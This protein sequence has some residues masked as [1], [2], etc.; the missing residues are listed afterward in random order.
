MIETDFL[1]VGGG[2]AGST[3]AKYLSISNI[4]NILIQKNLNFKKP[5]GGGVRQDAFDEFNLDTSI[6]LKRIHEIFL[7]FKTKRIKVDIKETPLAIV[8]RKQF[9]AYLRDE[10]KK[11]G[12]IVHEAK[13]LDFEI[14]EEYVISIVKF[15]E[16]IKQIKST[17]LIAADGVHSS[18][19]KKINGDTVISQLASYT[20]LIDYVCEDCEFHF[21]S[22]IA[23]KF[24]A[25]SF[26]ESAGTNIGTLAFEKQPYMHNFIKFLNIKEK[27]TIK[28][29][30]IPEFEN[31]L[32]YKRRVFFVGDSAS[33]VLPFTYEGIYYAMSSAKI[34]AEV[35]VEKCAPEEYERRWNKKYFRKFSTLKK[36]Q[37]IFLYNNFT[38]FIMMK[39]YESKSIRKKIVEL[40]L[41]DKEVRINLAFFLRVLKKIF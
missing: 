3:V 14:H 1:I 38:V 31:P 41:E 13:L 39:L 21:G 25:W 10:A 11:Q 5:C 9:D 2:P 35:L 12:T 30:K 4:P 32:F 37:K 6:I 17:Y 16:Q 23:D 26:P 40:W 27:S 7:V 22:E 19:R 34:L 33:Q 18:I 29:Y 24:Y 28:G 20:D 15:A 8:E 36:L